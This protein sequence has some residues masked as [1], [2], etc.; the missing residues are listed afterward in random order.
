MAEEY[1]NSI[2]EEGWIKGYR[3]GSFKADDDMTRAEFVTLINSL[4]ERYTK[5]ENMLEDIRGFP[6]LKKDSWYYDQMHEAINNHDYI[7]EDGE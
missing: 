5:V 2:E 1:I 3:D 7:I 4:L 6:D